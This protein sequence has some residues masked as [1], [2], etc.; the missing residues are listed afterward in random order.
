VKEWSFSDHWPV[1]PFLLA[2]RVW[3]LAHPEIVTKLLTMLTIFLLVRPKIKI[4][5]VPVTC[6]L[7]GR[8]GR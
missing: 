1:L 5:V 7:K 2:A 8:E 3:A 6:W 4:A